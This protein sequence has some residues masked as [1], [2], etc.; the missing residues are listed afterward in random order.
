MLETHIN[1]PVVLR[2]TLS[3][4]QVAQI[5]IKT[6]HCIYLPIFTTRACITYDHMILYLGN[7]GTP[8][9]S[10]MNGFL[11]AIEN[12]I[13]LESGQPHLSKNV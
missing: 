3:E 5:Y 10:Q 9:Y 4:K 11:V 8:D 6:L 1:L 13:F 12:Y 7:R 2:A